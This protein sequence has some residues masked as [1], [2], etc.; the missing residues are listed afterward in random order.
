MVFVVLRARKVTSDKG[1]KGEKGDDGNNASSVFDLIEDQNIKIKGIFEI[2][3]NGF[4]INKESDDTIPASKSIEWNT[5]T[6]SNTAC[7]YILVEN[8]TK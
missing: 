8:N 4:I 2:K 6:N 3:N 5:N 7:D 1:D